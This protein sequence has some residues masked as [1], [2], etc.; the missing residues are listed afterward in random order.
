MELICDS[1]LLNFI[2]FPFDGIIFPGVRIPLCGDIRVSQAP[3]N[4]N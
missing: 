3:F 4:H 1:R 2:Y